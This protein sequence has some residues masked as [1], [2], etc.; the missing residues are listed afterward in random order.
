[1]V[2]LYFCFIVLLCTQTS[3]AQ[4][5][6][7][8]IDSLHYQVEMQ[9]TL[10]NGDHT[11][12]WL[13]ANHYGLSSLKT[14]N[15]YLRAAVNRPVEYDSARHWALGYALDVA[16][17]TGFTSH[18]VV[19]QAYVEARWKRGLLTFGSK[20]QPMELKNQELSSGSQTFGINARPV[21]QLRLSLPDYWTLPILKGWVA[22]KGHFSYGMTTDDRWQ[23]D[24][25]QEQSK[26]TQKTF[27]HTKAGYLRIGKEGKPVSLE[28]GLEM[29][30]QF[31]GTS[32]VLREEGMVEIQ[33][34]ESPKAF[35]YAITSGGSDATD[36]A[37]R[38]SS[39]NT[40]GSWVGRLNIDLPSWYLGLYADHYFEDHSAMFFLDY[41]GYGSGDR[42][43]K[44]EKWRFFLY[45]LKDMLLGVD[46]R[47]KRCRWLENIVVEYIYTKYQS[48]PVY[49]DHTQHVSKHV[50]GRDNYYNHSLFTGNQH[51]GMV[52]GN[53]LYLSPLYNTDGQ[54]MVENNRFVAWH[55][56][57]SGTPIRQLHYRLLATWQQGFGTYEWIYPDP[58]EN[59]S[60]MAET[61]YR[62]PKG[63]WQLKAAVGMDSGKIY[64]DNVGF[65]FTI[66]K[67]GIFNR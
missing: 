22:I 56:G 1:M 41:D 17:P 59:V 7:S 38:N 16:V 67:S 46:L 11:P 53:P 6:R 50:S 26:Y 10:S 12:L 14:T 19:Q 30:S 2:R 62:F 45:D 64:G 4:R 9:A 51:W 27:L 23:R 63:G 54:I 35:L 3:L 39:G 42:W 32:Y 61:T 31:G 18:F 40:F 13:N 33:N 52:M 55:V 15:G 43:T 57:I 29:A 24:F 66:A 47:L 34:D 37:Y 49:H 20:E 44:K 8:P 60:L 25:T 21:P 28:L 65:Q 48:G 58:R 36:G 5:E